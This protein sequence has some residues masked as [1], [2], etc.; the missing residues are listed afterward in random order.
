MHHV[1]DRSAA[2]SSSLDGVDAVRSS[3][4]GARHPLGTAAAAYRRGG[5][6]PA[7]DVAGAPLPCIR[8]VAGGIDHTTTIC[9]G[10]GSRRSQGV[11]PTLP[12]T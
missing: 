12:G 11:A 10:E 6:D 1:V 9:A 8:G 3:S 4:C 2:A 7:R 5:R